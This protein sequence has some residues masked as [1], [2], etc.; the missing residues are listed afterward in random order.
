MYVDLG[1]Y[2]KAEQAFRQALRLQPL[3]IPAYVNFSQMLSL[4]KREKEAHDLLQTGILK[5]PQSADLYHALGLSQV[6]RKNMHA[7]LLSLEKA[8]SLQADN[9][10]YQYVY[11]VA[12][13]SSGKLDEALY[14]LQ[15]ALV[16]H[17]ADVDILYAL[18]TFNRDAG[19]YK[20]ALLY[21]QKLQQ[22]MPGNEAVS[23]L[24]QSL[25]R[26]SG[27]LNKK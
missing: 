14:V 5:N 6:R 18:V 17:P 12:L 21:A 16:R 23:K 4:Q 22:L 15:T 26:Q 11:A 7:A 27:T 19:H 10:R 13:Q 1:Q 2:E 9:Q 24:L 8:A 20:T 25:Q 3:F